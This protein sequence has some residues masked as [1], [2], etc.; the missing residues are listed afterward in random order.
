MARIGQAIYRFLRS[1]H[2]A[3]GLLIGLTL[4]AFAITLV[5]LGSADNPKVIEWAEAHPVAERF[6]VLLGLHHAY[7]TPLFL[8]A[9][10]LLTLSTAVCSWERTAKALDAWKR[11][12]TVD[13]AIADRLKT[14]PSFSIAAP[15][16]A[17]AEESLAFA[18]NTLRS[19]HMRVRRGPAL[20]EARQ[21]S[22]GL[23][24]SPLFHWGLVALFV[25]A[26]LGQLTRSEGM[27]R[28][29]I[30]EAPSEMHESYSWISE[31][32]LFRENHTGMRLWVRGLNNDIKVDGVLRGP[33]PD[34]ELGD[35]EGKKLKRQWIYPNNPLR[36][37]SIT[38]HAGEVGPALLMQ[39]VSNEQTRTTVFHFERSENATYGV[40]PLDIE[41]EGPEGVVPFRLEARPGQR[42]AFIPLRQV[43]GVPAEQVAGAGQNVKLPSGAVGTPLQFNGYIELNVVNDW[44]LPFIYAAFAIGL[45]GAT[46][47]LLLPP[48]VVMARFVEDEEGSRLNV[49]VS[50]RKTD[51]AFL[52]KVKAKLEGVPLADAASME[53]NR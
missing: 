6:A 5:P 50:A 19:I 32:P 35:A 4:Y 36:H 42:I 48:R 17:N 2:L 23:L 18:E 33:S 20:L 34:V 44:S 13:P 21:N 30:E 10:L 46:F 52:L 1:R 43:K 39:V 16:G 22:I 49:V 29:S 3:S 37:G 7:T 11:R 8:M 9:A 38:V 28:A 51:P 26:A 45:L 24:G 31:G 15:E 12:G 41:F 47:T 40:K 14:R 27:I 53:E 25:F